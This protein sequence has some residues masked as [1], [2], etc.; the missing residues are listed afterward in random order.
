R[1]PSMDDERGAPHRNLRLEQISRDQPA[2]DNQI[3]PLCLPEFRVRFL[4]ARRIGLR[5]RLTAWRPTENPECRAARLLG[6]NASEHTQAESR[7]LQ[8]ERCHDRAS[9]MFNPEQII[10]QE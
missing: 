9:I 3:E 2:I 6:I 10:V 7:N 8:R 5:L 4:K 1:S